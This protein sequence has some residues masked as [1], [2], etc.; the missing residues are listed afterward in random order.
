MLYDIL[1]RCCSSHQEPAATKG[2]DQKA[3]AAVAAPA[4]AVP[5]K[6]AAKMPEHSPTPPAAAAVPQVPEAPVPAGALPAGSLVL[7]TLKKQMM[8]EML[9]SFY[10]A[11]RVRVP[12]DTS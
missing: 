2:K 3:P 4:A 5:E 1:L 10:L 11:K 12:S 6:A 7:L 9:L 8:L